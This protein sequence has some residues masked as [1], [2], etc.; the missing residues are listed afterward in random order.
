[1]PAP[2]PATPR[3]TTN[4]IRGRP[5]TCPAAPQAN[6]RERPPPGGTDGA[7]ANG[8]LADG[9]GPTGSLPRPHPADGTVDGSAAWLGRSLD[10]ELLAP[11]VEERTG[12]PDRLGQPGPLP[13]WDAEPPALHGVDPGRVDELARDAI[14]RAWAMLVDDRPSGVRAPARADL[15]RRVAVDP[16]RLV[17][18]ASLAGVTTGRL[19]DWARAWAIAGDDAV[20][21]V[22]D[23]R[24]WSED[25]D[26]LEAARDDLVALDSPVDPSR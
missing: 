19:D 17:E 7:A 6:R 5:S 13:H 1:M 16:D 10:D 11:P 22:A 26:R 20:A 2:S 4:A 8:A 14:E 15:A 25:Q 21:V 3:S 18:L 24:S 9:P 12:S 23:P